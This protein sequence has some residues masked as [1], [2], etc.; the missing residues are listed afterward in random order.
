MAYASANAIINPQ[1][2]RFQNYVKYQSELKEMKIKWQKFNKQE[3]YRIEG[4]DCY[5]LRW[6]YAQARKDAMEIPEMRAIIERL[7]VFYKADYPVHHKF[8]GRG[9][10]LSPGKKQ[11]ESDNIPVTIADGGIAVAVETARTTDQ[12]LVSKDVYGQLTEQ[13]RQRCAEVDGVHQYATGESGK[14]SMTNPTGYWPTGSGDFGV[15]IGL[16]PG[17][18]K[19]FT[20][21]SRTMDFH[22]SRIIVPSVVFDVGIKMNDIYGLTSGCYQVATT[23]VKRIG[24][25]IGEG[26]DEKTIRKKLESFILRDKKGW[27]GSD[28]TIYGKCS[29]KVDGIFCYLTARQGEACLQF[30]NGEKWIGKSELD[31]ECAFEM[32]GDILYLLYVDVYKNNQV[33]LNKDLQDYFRDQLEF[34]IHLDGSRTQPIAERTL[35]STKIQDNLPHDGIVVW[36]LVRQAFFKE[37]NTVDITRSMAEV[38]MKE[39]DVD[40]ERYEEMV[41]GKIYEFGVVDNLHLKY[42]KIR[43]PLSKILPNMLRSVRRALDDPNLGA[44]RDHHMACKNKEDQDCE[45]CKY[46]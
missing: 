6:D 38:L 30:R 34:I 17:V 5:L 14:V 39:D 26:D 20:V 31:V 1:I 15:T 18:K 25:C 3:K 21:V 37:I 27:H 36:G 8:K 2:D 24:D 46:I 22:L 32:V 7:H 16:Q 28:H 33:F 13:Q 45:I 19:T 41:D 44:V 29:W 23:G 40:V 43:D 10:E 12:M 11:M 9:V 42:I 4:D 35:V